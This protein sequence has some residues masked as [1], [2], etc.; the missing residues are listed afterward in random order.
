M[1]K[2]LFNSFANFRETFCSTSPDGSTESRQPSRHFHVPSNFPFCGFPRCVNIEL[3]ARSGGKPQELFMYGGIKNDSALEIVYPMFIFIS[4]LFSLSSPAWFQS[5]KPIFIFSQRPQA[6]LLS[7]DFSSIYF[8]VMWI[9]LS[10]F[11]GRIRRAVRLKTELLYRCLGF[12]FSFFSGSQWIIYEDQFIN[13]H[14]PGGARAFSWKYTFDFIC[15]LIWFDGFNDKM[16]AWKGKE[17][18]K[19]LSTGNI[20]D[21]FMG[22]TGRWGS[23][24]G[25]GKRGLISFHRREQT[26]KFIAGIFWACCWIL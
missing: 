12:P 18:S 3:F 6:E 15:D 13:H 23:E 19:D 25:F 2:T 21:S 9:W 11:V 14:R 5:T 1:L 26:M 4:Q 7:A 16:C 20:S 17:S 10:T 8:L 24:K 22:L